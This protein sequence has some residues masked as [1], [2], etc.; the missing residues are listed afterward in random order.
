MVRGETGLDVCERGAFLDCRIRTTTKR[1]KSV[2]SSAAAA[3]R[4]VGAGAA[5][6]KSGSREIEKKSDSTRAKPPDDRNAEPQDDE[7]ASTAFVDGDGNPAS[8]RTR[9]A[10]S[11]RAAL[12]TYSEADLSSASIATR[13]E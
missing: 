12:D 2:T 6:P 13:S 11:P 5:G 9:F 8:V 3:R 4:C 10:E 1:A 7:P